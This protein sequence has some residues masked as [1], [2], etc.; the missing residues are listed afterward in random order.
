MAQGLQGPVPS[1]CPRSA[2]ALPSAVTFWLCA[3]STPP[4]PRDGGLQRG[5][6]LHACVP[7]LKGRHVPR[8]LGAF[9]VLTCWGISGAWR[10]REVS[11]KVRSCGRGAGDTHGPVSGPLEKRRD[12]AESAVEGASPPSGTPPPSAAQSPARSLTVTER[13]PRCRL[14][15]FQA[16]ELVTENCEAYEAHMRGVRDYLEER[17]VVRAARP[18]PAS[19][20]QRAVRVGARPGRGA[21]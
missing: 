7:P 17:L 8:G 11:K 12:A 10:C 20:S 2:L 6:P 5:P 4:P 13:F 16:A 18:G 3:T 9:L 15:V 14:P 1:L 21:R 19:F